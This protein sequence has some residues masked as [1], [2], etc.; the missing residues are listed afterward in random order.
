[1]KSVVIPD[2][3]FSVVAGWHPIIDEVPA[4]KQGVPIMHRDTRVLLHLMLMVLSAE[5]QFKAVYFVEGVLSRGHLEHG[6]DFDRMYS[7]I[8]LVEDAVLQTNQGLFNVGA[9]LQNWLDYYY[10]LKYNA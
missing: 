2:I 4:V 9:E 7:L 8:P 6:R 5:E 10:H 3:E 1:M